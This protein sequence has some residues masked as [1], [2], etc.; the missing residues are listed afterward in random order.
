[1]SQPIL[2]RR[3]ILC[4][5][6]LWS[7][8]T[9]SF[10]C[11]TFLPTNKASSHGIFINW[12]PLYHNLHTVAARYVAWSVRHF[13]LKWKFKMRFYRTK[14][15]KKRKAIANFPFNLWCTSTQDMHQ[16]L[17][18]IYIPHIYLCTSLFASRHEISS[19]QETKMLARV[20]YRTWWTS[21]AGWNFLRASPF[22]LPG[23][24]E[25]PEGLF[26]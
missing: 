12:R 5:F 11:P 20:R 10:V 13:A 16:H 22:E 1:M 8:P 9:A 21:S 15:H 4:W 23:W 17:S 25:E 24:A 26:D 6:M 18:K 19:R 14:E 3:D 2:Q 7:G